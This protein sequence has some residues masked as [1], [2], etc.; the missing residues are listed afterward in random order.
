[1]THR[2]ETVMQAV[3]TA[4]T[5]LTL[6]GANVERGDPYTTESSKLPCLHVAMGP[7]NKQTEYAHGEADWDLEVNI[8]GTVRAVSNYEQT[9]NDIREDV[10]IALRAAPQL[11]ET[12]VIDTMEAD[13]DELVSDDNAEQV[14][15]SQTWNWIV[16]YRRS[17]DDPGN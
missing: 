13:P 2:V 12:F 5:G 16:K 3:V 11:G 1:M 9:L 6:T 7:E 8:T 4:V 17:I 14:T 15:V 10:H